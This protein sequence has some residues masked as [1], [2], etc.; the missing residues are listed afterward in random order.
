[1]LRNNFDLIVFDW[2]GTL[3]DS[4]AVIVHAIQA[5]A[6]DVGLAVPSREQASYVIGLGL[7]DALQHAVPELP[8]SRYP[9]LAERYRHHYVQVEHQLSFF[10]GVDALLQDLKQH[11]YLLAVATGKSRIGL[12]RALDQMTSRALFDTTRT[13]D[14]TRSKPHP[15]MLLEIMAA[16][17]IDP[18]RTLMIG[19]TTHDLQLAANAGAHAVAVAYGAHDA[20]PL[21]AMKPQFCA[22]SVQQLHDWLRVN[23]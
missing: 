13:A 20:T 6:K 22:H 2:D 21:T 8:E 12:A 10:D 3:Y 23:G 5:A 16:T 15:Q 4:T 11:N 14:E 9:E 7:K 18:K 17:G 19:D 1:M